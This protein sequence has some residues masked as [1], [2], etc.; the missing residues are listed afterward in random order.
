MFQDV[1]VG[2]M[3]PYFTRIIINTYIKSDDSNY[4]NRFKQL[5]NWHIPHSE[6]KV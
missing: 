5:S 1:N 6:K 2:Y 4:C 3:N